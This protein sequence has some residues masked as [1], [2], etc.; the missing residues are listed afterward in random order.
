MHNLV[1]H[2]YHIPGTLA[3][4]LDIRFTAPVGLT[5]LHVSAAC[6]NQSDARLS[7]GAPALEQTWLAPSPAG[8]EAAPRS[9]SRSD[10]AG[11]QCPRLSAGEAIRLVLDYDGDNGLP[12]K[13]VTLALTFAAG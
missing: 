6:S 10:F 4:D 1:T 13:D 11:G 8:A 2:T 9:Y 3:A 7:I 12:A 5:L